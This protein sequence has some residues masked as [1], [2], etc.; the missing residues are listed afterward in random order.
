MIKTLV[1]LPRFPIHYEFVED[2]L[3]AMQKA[4]GGYIGKLTFEEGWCVI[5]DVEGLRKTR[6][7]NCEIE[8]VK[9]FGKI[10]FIGTEGDGFK[11]FENEKEL[12]KKY[13]HLWKEGTVYEQK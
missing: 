5:C 2:N 11:D 13:P 9:L 1:K 6:P 12:K 8:G 4:I 7:Y 3:V 10:M